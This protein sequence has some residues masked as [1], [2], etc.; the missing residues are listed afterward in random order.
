MPARRWI[1][2]PA[3]WLVEYNVSSFHCESY[4]SHCRYTLAEVVSNNGI[5]IGSFGGPGN[6]SE[7]YQSE[8]CQFVVA[9]SFYVLDSK[10]R[11]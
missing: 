8:I 1:I 5:N 11:R 2:E 3:S 6:L 4:P 7:S 10:R 9:N